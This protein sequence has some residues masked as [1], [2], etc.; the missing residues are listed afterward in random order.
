MHIANKKNV[1]CPVCKTHHT[2]CALY[3]NV[4]MLYVPCS[5]ALMSVHHGFPPRTSQLWVV[6]SF[7]FSSPLSPSI[8]VLARITQLWKCDRWGLQP[9]PLLGAPAPRGWQV[10]PSMLTAPR[11]NRRPAEG[12]LLGAIRG[13]VG[14]HLATWGYRLLAALVDR[15][16]RQHVINFFISP[17]IVSPDATAPFITASLSTRM[18]SSCHWLA[19]FLTAAYFFLFFF[20]L[21]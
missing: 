13:T 14:E 16:I 20:F 15:R 5:N 3:L 17:C 4:C 12:C 7:F 1:P 10:A 9:R 6:F 11:G 8:F 19:V 18:S 21:E 2:M